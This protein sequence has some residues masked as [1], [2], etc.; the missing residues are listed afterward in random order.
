MIIKQSYARK[1]TFIK[2]KIR[3][4]NRY[5]AYTFSNLVDLI[6][7][8]CCEYINKI[9]ILTQRIQIVNYNVTKTICAIKPDKQFS[10]DL[11]TELA[12]YEN[13]QL[14]LYHGDM[15]FVPQSFTAKL[16]YFFGAIRTF[17]FKI[18]MN[19]SYTNRDIPIGAPMMM[20]IRRT[21][22]LPNCI[23][24]KIMQYV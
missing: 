13:C 2:Y 9:R 20:W 10:R 24:D 21:T 23:F 15:P 17:S 1:G 7:R 18:I 5:I 8:L 6:K 12:Q 19:Y 22:I 4:T 14:H 3:D 16:N 11:F